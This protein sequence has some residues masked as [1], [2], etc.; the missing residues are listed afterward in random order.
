MIKEHPF[1]MPRTKV[2]ISQYDKVLKELIM[3]SF[4]YNDDIFESDQSR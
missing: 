1:T 4:D 3:S 2:D